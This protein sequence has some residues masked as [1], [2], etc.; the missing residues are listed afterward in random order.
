MDSS[1]LCVRMREIELLS[2]LSEYMIITV[3]SLPSAAQS[4]VYEI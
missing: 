2:F 3:I 4:Y 1:R